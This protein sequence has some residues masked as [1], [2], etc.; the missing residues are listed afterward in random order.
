MHTY[1][2]IHSEQPDDSI[3]VPQRSA[4]GT[5]GNPFGLCRVGQCFGFDQLVE[6]NAV[7]MCGV[8][9]QEIRVRSCREVNFLQA[10]NL[11]VE[12]EINGRILVRPL[13]V[14]GSR[15]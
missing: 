6:G 13:L 10:E 12:Q 7:A 2:E 8:A 1:Q 4:A 9:K 11:R 5:E 3:P 15:K 14:R